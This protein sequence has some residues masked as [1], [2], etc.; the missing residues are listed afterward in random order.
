[1]FDFNDSTMEGVEI[2]AFVNLDRFIGIWVDTVDDNVDVDVIGIMVGGVDGL[3]LVHAHFIEGNFDGFVDL[4]GGWFFM[5]SPTE[6]I[7]VDR[8]FTQGVATG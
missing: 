3:M 7:V 1:M 6:D 2:E 4:F 5:F 8:I